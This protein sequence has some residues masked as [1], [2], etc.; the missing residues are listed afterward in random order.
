[1]LIAPGDVAPPSTPSKPALYAFFKNSCPTCQ[2]A[3][4]VVAELARRYGDAIP[5]VAVAQDK[6]KKAEP[7]LAERGFAGPV[8]DD[9]SKYPLSRAY[10]IMTVPTLVLVDD[11]GRVVSTSV[12]WS[13]DRYNEWARELG[14][15][16]G[17]T[18]EPVSTESDGRPGLKPG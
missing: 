17:R 1:V 13:R 10:G 5:V 12:G 7:W 6:P 4:P 18:T 3:F 8:I 15:R 16:T 14:E 2:L 9:S 11:T